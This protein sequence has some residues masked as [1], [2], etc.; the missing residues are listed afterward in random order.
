M[1]PVRG[2]VMGGSALFLMRRS[3]IVPMGAADRSARD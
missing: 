1:R 2:G 3:A